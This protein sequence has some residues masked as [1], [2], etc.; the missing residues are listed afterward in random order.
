MTTETYTI[1][2][3]QI[4]WEYFKNEDPRPLGRHIHHDSRSKMFRVVEPDRASISVEWARK[5]PVLDQGD[6]GSCT[7][8]AAVGCVGTDPNHSALPASDGFIGTEDQAIAIYERATVLDGYA[9]QY[10]PTDT[11]SDGLSAAKACQE[12]GWISGY[13]HALSVDDVIAGLQSGPG[14]CGTNWHTGQD[15]PT[16]TGLV[17]PTG[18]VRG[19]HEYECYKVDLNKGLLYFWNSWGTGFGVGGM[20]NM[21]L[22]SMAQLLSEQGDATFFTPISQPAPTPTPTPSTMSRTFTSSDYQAIDDWAKS[23]HIFRLASSASKAWKR[24]S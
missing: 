14:I 3:E 4:P 19:G 18:S 23:P 13:T 17:K 10:P 2:H 12:K 5:I 15:K 6:L 11:G 8:N 22:D 7:G 20:F 24:G 9:G 16:T 21:S 1:E